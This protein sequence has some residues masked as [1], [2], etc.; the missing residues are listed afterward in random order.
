MA[1]TSHDVDR[2]RGRALLRLLLVAGATWL[3]ASAALPAFGEEA[4]GGE[5]RPP[6]AGEQDARF[7]SA[8]PELEA[9]LEEAGRDA[10]VAEVRE[11]LA[12]AYER[13][14]S[15]PSRLGEEEREGIVRALRWAVIL[16]DGDSLPA[17]ERLAAVERGEREISSYFHLAY[18]ARWAAWHLHGR[19]W[20]LE[21]RVAT[22]A[23]LRDSDDAVA[24]VFAGDRLLEIGSDA[25]PLLL[26]RA[27]A[28]ILEAGPPETKP[29]SAAELEATLRYLDET[30]FLA[31]F[32]ETAA[33][34]AAVEALLTDPAPEVRALAR[35]VLD[36]ATPPAEP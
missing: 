19:A 36:L 26:A 33:D 5:G 13:L 18:M 6:S 11:R 22:L 10:V 7:W 4:A 25:L 35:E 31:D 34:R 9:R 27:R 3:A 28:W 29:R 16:D 32:V 2:P 30:A 20:P 14:R 15:D 21:R 1:R 17:I 8:D 23:E 12:A 24:Q